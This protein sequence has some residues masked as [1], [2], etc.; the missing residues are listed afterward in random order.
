[1]NC[2][3]SFTVL[4]AFGLASRAIV[5][6]RSMKSITWWKSFSLKFLDV[7]AG[8][9]RRIPPGTRADLSPGQVFLL[10]VRLH[11]FMTDSSRA[12]SRPLGRRSSRSRWLSVPP[13][14]TVYPFASKA[15]TMALA[16]FKTCSWYA[17]NW[18]VVA[19]FSATATEAMAWL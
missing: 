17:R 2:L 9:P 16:F 3:K 6:A 13:D 1:M 5:T 10:A 12:P 15:V 19:C 7:S 8:A 18:G 4:P 14:T 11:S